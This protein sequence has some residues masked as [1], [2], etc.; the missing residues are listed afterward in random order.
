MQSFLDYLMASEDGVMRHSQDS[1]LKLGL[2][3]KL[4][5][6]PSRTLAV[7]PI[8]HFSFDNKLTRV[9]SLLRGDHRSLLLETSD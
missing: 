2:Y 8:E 9:F 4:V 7:D 6:F 3:Y 5:R 1:A